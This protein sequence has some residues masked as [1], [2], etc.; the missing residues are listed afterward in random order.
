MPKL[1][2]LCG[3]KFNKLLIV[4]RRGSDKL[5][6]P[7]WLCKCDCGN[8]KICRGDKVKTGKIKSCG[9]NNQQQD[10]G[11][12][13]TRLY[14]IFVGM[15]DRCY[16]KHNSRYKNYGNRGIKICDEWLTDFVKFYSWAMENGYREGL[17]IERVDVNGN[18]EPNNCSWITIEE[19]QKNKTNSIILDYNG[20]SLCISEWAKILNIPAS[21]L[22]R[23][24][25]KGL[26][27]EQILKE[28]DNECYNEQSNIVKM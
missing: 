19:Q 6:H 26:P 14:H 23:Q 9:C 2:D 22:Y 16:N 1:I 28:V 17:T 8:Y 7:L 27:V 13:H 21:K 4:E 12:C 10:H 3:Q 15:K 5:G 25:H 18:Y 11:L 20:K 24:Y